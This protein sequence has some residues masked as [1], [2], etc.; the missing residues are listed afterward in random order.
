MSST[1]A[2]RTRERSTPGCRRGA[3]SSRRASSTPTCT[4][5]ATAGDYLLHDMVK[6]DYRTANY[7]SFAAPLKGTDGHAAGGGGGRPP[8]LRVPACAQG[9]VHHH[10]RRRRAAGGLGRLR[11]PGGRAGRAR[12]RE[13]V[14]PRPQH[15]HR[16]GGPHL[17]RQR[18]RRRAARAWTSRSS[19]SGPTTA[20]PAGACGGCSTPPRSRRAAS[21]CCGRAGMRPARWTCPCTRTPGATSSSSPASWRSTAGPRSGS[22]PTSASSTI[23][24]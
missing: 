21:R 5:R 14:V 16:P 8:H 6:N 19:S 7:L 12:L 18:S 15:L 20:P 24:R 10:H 3:C 9:R 23:A 17:L 22:W 13:P 4:P 11:A 2:A 1:P